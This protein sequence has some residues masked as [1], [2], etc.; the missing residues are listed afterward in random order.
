MNGEMRV[1]SIMNL[2]SD[3]GNTSFVQLIVEKIAS[4]GLKRKGVKAAA[5]VFSR[6]V[7]FQTNNKKGLNFYTETTLHSIWL[8]I[9]T[10]GG[11]S[12]SMLEIL[13]LKRRLKFCFKVRTSEHLFMFY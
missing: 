12:L 6:T 11:L 7:K 10:S 2:S 9:P 1:A 4:I 13:F 5:T 8:S 3:F